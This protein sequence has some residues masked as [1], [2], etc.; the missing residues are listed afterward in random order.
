MHMLNRDKRRVQ[1]LFG[2]MTVT[3]SETTETVEYVD[4]I[5]FNLDESIYHAIPRLS[6]SGIQSIMVSP[7]TFWVNSWLNP[8]KE[9]RED[10]TPARLLGRAYHAA[11]FEP[12]TFADRF[13]RDLEKEDLP[14]ALNTDEQIKAA[15]EDLGQPKTKAGE[16]VLERAAR[17][18][19]AGYEG[20]V[21][22]FERMLFEE[23]ILEGQV[24]IKGKYYDQLIEDMKRIHQNPEV[25]VHLKGGQAEVSV[26]W[27]CPDTG[28]PMKCRFDYLRPTAFTDFKT[29]ENSKRKRLEQCI[30]EAFRYNRYYIQAA[31]YWRTT[32]IIQ[33]G[34]LDIIGYASP[35][36]RG[37]IDDIKLNPKPLK[38][39][40]IFQE[41]SGVP[42]LM[43]YDIEL[44]GPPASFEPNATGLSESEYDA[45][46]EAQS[47]KT[48]LYRKAEIEIAHA[49]RTFLTYREVYPDGEPWFPIRPIGKINDQS[50]SSYWLDEIAG[51]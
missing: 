33:S 45:A 31:G 29:F 48:V 22:H 27:T 11:R 39:W 42:N 15:L 25:A 10:D 9:E 47:S 41:K 8:N 3:E 36:Q 37:L 7:A 6:F 14:K 28:I 26:L 16:K 2:E 24:P 19:D 43:A 23:S 5:Y 30:E 20:Q 17:L 1:T 35:E 40:Y 50:F 12:E 51:Q 4:G 49:K 44:I 46:R 34:A 21:W 38:V 13:I 18:I 32:E